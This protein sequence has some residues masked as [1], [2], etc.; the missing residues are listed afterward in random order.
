MFGIFLTFTANVIL[1]NLIVAMM[2]D[3]YEEV[4][5]TIEEKN[6]KAKNLMILYFSVKD[7]FNYFRAIVLKK[8]ISERAFQLTSDA[9]ELNPANYT[10]W[11][12]R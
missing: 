7:I 3:S 10:V 5:T 8:E 9:L 11:Q 12:Y 2:S 1:L 4:I 6:Q